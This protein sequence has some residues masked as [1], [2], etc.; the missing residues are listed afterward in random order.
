MIT[1]EERLASMEA[2]LKAHTENDTEQFGELK[3]LMHDMNGKLDGLRLSEAGRAAVDFQTKRSAG[4]FGG[5]VAAFLVGV[6]EVSKYFFNN[7][8]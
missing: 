6:I 7:V 4:F 3:D 2:T 5:S 8:R 1:V